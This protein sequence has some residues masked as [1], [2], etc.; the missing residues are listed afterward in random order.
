MSADASAASRRAFM[1]RAF[2]YSMLL[3]VVA[4]AAAALSIPA[5]MPVGSFPAR[6]LRAVIEAPPIIIFSAFVLAA[7]AVGGP[8]W[9]AL[10]AMDFARHRRRRRRHQAL[11][12]RIVRSQGG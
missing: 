10:V 8:L 11:L 2:A 1:V 4:V 6:V 9:I 3:A 7:W 5:F 12:E